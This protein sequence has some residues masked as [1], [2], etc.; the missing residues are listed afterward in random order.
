MPLYHRHSRLSARR[1]GL[2]RGRRPDVQ[3]ADAAI[4]DLIRNVGGIALEGVH[5]RRSGV[6]GDEFP[7]G[8]F[9]LPDFAIDIA[10]RR[11]R[12]IAIVVLLSTS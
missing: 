5:I 11:P 2:L 7:E 9:V 3:S 1:N 6:E 8:K 12:Q 10:A 4:G